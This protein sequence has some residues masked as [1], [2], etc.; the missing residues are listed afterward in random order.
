[1]E[2]Q[3]FVKGKK[4]PLVYKGDRIDILDFKMDDVDYK[5]VR[6]FN[7]KKGMSK[8]EFVQ[9]NLIKKIVTNKK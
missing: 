2:V 8:S 1:M 6:Y 7:F 3:I 9:E 5:Q 4:D